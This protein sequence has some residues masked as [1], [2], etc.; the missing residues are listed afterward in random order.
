MTERTVDGGFTAKWARWA[1]VSGAE[2]LGAIRAVWSSLRAVI[3]ASVLPVFN[4]L[5]VSNLLSRQRSTF[6]L[7]E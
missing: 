5:L 3:G 4:G 2:V 7:D 6:H 1:V